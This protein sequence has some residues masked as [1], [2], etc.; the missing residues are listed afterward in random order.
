MSLR[1]I[2]QS[3]QCAIDDPQL[4]FLDNPQQL[5]SFIE[6]ARQF[7]I[8]ADKTEITVQ[9]AI[10]RAIVVAMGKRSNSGYRMELTATFAQ[11]ENDTLILP[12]IFYRPEARQMTA[13]IVTSPCIVIAVNTQEGYRQ[14]QAGELS[15]EIP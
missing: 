13:Q 6:S 11:I 7:N 12:V 3:Q 15:A 1:N 10:G 2:Y 14:V 9:P 8:T 4:I 5:Y